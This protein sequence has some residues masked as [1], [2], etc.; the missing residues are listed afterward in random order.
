M[1]LTIPLANHSLVFT[2][3]PKD[4]IFSPIAAIYTFFI[5]PPEPANNSMFLE[6]EKSFGELQNSIVYNLL[7][8][9]IATN[10]K[11]P[12]WRAIAS[13]VNLNCVLNAE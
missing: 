8:V 3:Y 9:G 4:T 12:I 13:R 11:T 10:I 5:L 7:Y 1:K 6:N 2:L